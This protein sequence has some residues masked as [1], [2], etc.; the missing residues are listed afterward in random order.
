LGWHLRVGVS[1]LPK[2]F[3]SIPGYVFDDGASKREIASE[4]HRSIKSYLHTLDQKPIRVTSKRE[5][6]QLKDTDQLK[7]THVLWI[8]E[9]L[10]WPPRK[11]ERTIERHRSI[12]SYLQTLDQK[13]IRVMSNMI[14]LMP[15]CLDIVEP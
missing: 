1:W 9:P 2:T 14:F 10:E 12:K 4:R 7:A 13:P 11:R 5:R 8:K 3:N 6:E 15:K